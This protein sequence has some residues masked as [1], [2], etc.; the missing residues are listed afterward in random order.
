MTDRAPIRFE[1]AAFD[2]LFPFHLILDRRL[3]IIRV[4]PMLRRVMPDLVPPAALTEHFALRRP[5]L[6]SVDFDTFRG[7]TETIFLLAAH[8]PAELVLRGQM[9]PLAEGESLA[10]LGSP[11]VTTLD[12]LS[13][14]AL[15]VSDF[16]IHDPTADLLFL[17]QAQKTAL[18]DATELATQLRDARDSALKASQVKSEF[19][20]H[21][22][23]ELRTPLN[24]ILGFSETLKATVF[25]PLPE[26]YRTYAEHIHDS[27][28]RLLDLINDL[29]D[30]SRIE[31]GRFEL[32]EAP[33]DVAT[34]LGECIELV[35]DDA[36]RKSIQVVLD[37]GPSGLTLRADRRAFDQI[38]LNLLSN[39]VKFTNRGGRVS[40]AASV[41][42]GQ[43]VIVVADTGIGISPDVIAHLFEPFRQADAEISRRYGGTGLGLNICRNLVELHGGTIAIESAVSRGTTV[44]V[45]FPAGRTAQPR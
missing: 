37:A 42:D 33:V 18:E 14:L 30:L 16:A 22:S 41:A 40:I 44:T 2:R 3:A 10:F 34:A 25:G 43:A 7:E 6:V 39:A 24:A 5:S 9:A 29:L 15:T 13:S 45:R 35:T 21:M 8:H 31:A 27:G 17:I 32:D 20:A 19:L 23:H 11:W 38:V 1:P 12:Q 26:R 36:R 4:G 28:R